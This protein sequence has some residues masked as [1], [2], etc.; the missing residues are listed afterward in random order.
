M[1]FARAAPDA[2]FAV[3]FE[4]YGFGEAA[5]GPLE[6]EDGEGGPEVGPC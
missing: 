2:G 3:E 4:D 5:H 6:E 1:E